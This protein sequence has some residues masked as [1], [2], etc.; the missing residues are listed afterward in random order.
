MRII[1]DI[2]DFSKIEAGKLEME[3]I[4]FSLYDQLEHAVSVLAARANKKGLE[5]AC[6]VDQSVPDQIIGDPG[7]LFQVFV[8]LIGNWLLPAS[9]TLSSSKHIIDVMPFIIIIFLSV[10]EFPIC[11]M[12]LM[13]VLLLQ[14][15][16]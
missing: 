6:Q 2:L 15:I 8:N 7:R 3:D 11:W 5:L 14:A 10:G 9:C 4:Q 16:A 12:P 13:E 1:T